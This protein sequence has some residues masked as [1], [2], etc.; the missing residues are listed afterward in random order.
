MNLM[1]HMIPFFPDREGSVDV[2]QGMI[3]GGARYIEIQFP[4]SD[5]TA[6]GPTIQGASARALANGFTV[7]KGWKFV[8]DAVAYVGRRKVDVFVMSY[9]S[10]VFVHGI[11]RFVEKAASVGVK[12]LIVPDLPIDYDEGLYAAGRTHSV[13][14]VPVIA[15]GASAD[16]IALTK[17]SN[18]EF[19]YASLR[20]GTTGAYTEIGD[21]NVAFLR[22]LRHGGTKIVAGF[23]IS[24]PEQVA[25]VL[26]HADAAVIGSAFVRCAEGAIGDGGNSGARPVYTAVRRETERLAGTHRG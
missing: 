8:E 12:G 16:R 11:D 14:I 26:A 9:A 19:V 17:R 21:E 25:A 3:D 18:S 24:T 4:F 5:P 15:L 10:P 6:D 2:F 22:S 20:R 23:G 7:Q 13:A 1:T